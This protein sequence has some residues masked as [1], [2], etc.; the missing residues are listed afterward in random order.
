MSYLILRDLQQLKED[1]ELKKE[2]CL[3]KKE[4]Y[5]LGDAWY[6]KAMGYED[7]IEKIEKIL[8]KYGRE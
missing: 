5:T 1:L 4:K 7:A 2:D 8:K 3:A 6:G